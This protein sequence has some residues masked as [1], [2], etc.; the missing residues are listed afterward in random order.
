MKKKQ[1]CC[2]GSMEEL[3]DWNVTAWCASWMHECFVTNIF[4]HFAG[5]RHRQH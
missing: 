2:A 3:T 5:G 4:Q 1:E